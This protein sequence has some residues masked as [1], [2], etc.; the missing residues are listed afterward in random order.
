MEQIPERG[1]S[2][3]TT[4]F[5]FITNPLSQSSTLELLSALGF[6][7]QEGQSFSFGSPLIRNLVN[8]SPHLEQFIPP[9]YPCHP[10]MQ[11]ELCPTWIFFVY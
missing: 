8:K 7:L 10:I 6:L 2:V 1:Q 5:S 9:T 3:S 11:P 4:L